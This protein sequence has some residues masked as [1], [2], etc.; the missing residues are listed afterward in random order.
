MWAVVDEA[1]WQWSQ[2]CQLVLPVGKCI[3]P[4]IAMSLNDHVI[5]LPVLQCSMSF[6]WR[7]FTIWTAETVLK[8]KNF[9]ETLRGKGFLFYFIFKLSLTFSPRVYHM[10]F[11]LDC[12]L[13][14]NVLFWLITFSSF[15]FP[16]AKYKYGFPSFFVRNT[17][18]TMIIIILFSI[19]ISSEPC[20]RWSR[21]KNGL[22]RYGSPELLA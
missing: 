17:F 22:S 12:S 3:S 15:S 13:S 11:I 10:Q 20:G 2:N 18:I 14:L 6:P 1:L 19:I 9:R 16:L 21:G 8:G 5:M 4:Y 7:H